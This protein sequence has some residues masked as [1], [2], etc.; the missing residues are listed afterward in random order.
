MS[1]GSAMVAVNDGVRLH[2]ETHG[3]GRPLVLIGG[4]RMSTPWWRKQVSVLGQQFQVIALDMRGYGESDKSAHG[5]RVARHAKDV[6]DV[7]DQLDLD[8]VTLVGWSMGASTM[9]AYAELFGAHRIKSF[10]M[11]DQT[12]RI[13]SDADWQLG[14]GTGVFPREQLDGFLAGILKDDTAFLRGF[15]PSMFTPTNAAN[16]TQDELAWMLEAV[17][18]MPT[19]HAVAVLDD[20]ISQDWRPVLPTIKVPTLVITGRLSTVFPYQSSLYVAEQIPD[21]RVV[22]FEESAHLP[23]YEEPERFNS[24]VA[25]F[26]AE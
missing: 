14:L 18:Q 21:A 22:V 24:E 15:L 16:L 10:V 25:A 26:A 20:H 12:P 5:N 8:K 19:A 3:S 4:W 13:L 17:Q 7:L 11:V 2:Y 1:D 23:F 9:M 6:Y